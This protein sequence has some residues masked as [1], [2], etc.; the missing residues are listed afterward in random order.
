MRSEIRDLT[1]DAPYEFINDAEYPIHAEYAS[2]TARGVEQCTVMV[3]G[4]VVDRVYAGAGG[5]HSW[6]RAAGGPLTPN[7]IEPG[8]TLKITVS[9]PAAFRV[10]WPE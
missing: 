10:D 8:G 7:P 2:I 4:A 3:D 6:W 5:S 9:G 1:P